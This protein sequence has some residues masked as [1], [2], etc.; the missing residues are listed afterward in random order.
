[1]K[2]LILQTGTSGT[3][4]MGQIIPL[5]LIM[6]VFYVFM[7]LPQM[8]KQKKQRNFLSEIKKGD[9]VVTTGGMHGKV[10]S[11][12]EQTLVLETEGGN[13]IKFEKA[14]VSLEMTKSSYADS[15]K[16]E[17]KSE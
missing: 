2:Y 6:A 9:H 13:R 14:A 11:V 17:E 16:A 7:I 4:T 8:R 12:Q 5:I 15:G 10:V 3:G 1:M